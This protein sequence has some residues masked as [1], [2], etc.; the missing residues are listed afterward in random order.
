MA[1]PVFD[2][3][4]YD[5]PGYFLIIC[6]DI[7][8]NTSKIKPLKLRI[9]TTSMIQRVT[10]PGGTLFIVSDSLQAVHSRAEGYFCLMSPLQ[11]QKSSW[12]LTVRF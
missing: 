8:N 2:T 11:K 1:G 4:L 12:F 10:L 3:L 5:Q 6:S 7:Y 9:K